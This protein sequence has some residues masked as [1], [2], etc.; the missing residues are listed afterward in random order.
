MSVTTKKRGD[1]GEKIAR[2]YLEERAFTI[3]ACNYMPSRGIKRGEIDIIAQ[4]GNIIHFIEVKTRFVHSGDIVDPPETQITRSKIQAL[5]RTAQIYLKEKACS[6]VTYVF[7]ALAI[8][9]YPREKKA[10]VRFL[11]D[12][13]L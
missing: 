8:T 2:R 9:I 4:K 7:D 10:H 5:N 6:G 11:E 12:I 1:Y 13:F 3:L